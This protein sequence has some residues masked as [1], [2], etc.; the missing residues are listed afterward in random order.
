MF[1]LSLFAII[2]LAMPSSNALVESTFSIINIVQYKIINQIMLTLLNSIMDVK[3]YFSVNNIYCKNFEGTSDVISR[4]KSKIY[5]ETAT[6]TLEQ[7]E[8]VLSGPIS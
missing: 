5:Q 3:V 4:F 7:D 1:Y 6:Q 2:M 8:E